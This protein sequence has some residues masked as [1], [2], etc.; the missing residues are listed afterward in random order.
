[1]IILPAIDLH[2]GQCV[3]LVK[4]DYSTAKQVAFDPLE[5]ALQFEKEGASWL[6]MVDLDGAKGG[7][8]P[9]KEIILTI[10]KNSSL[11]VELGGGIRDFKTAVDYLEQGVER[12]ILGSMALENPEIIQQLVARYPDRIAVGIDA[13]DG[14]VKTNGWLKESNQNYLELAKKMESIGV[15]YIIFT[16]ISKD[17]TLKGPNLEQLK[18]IRQAVN[19]HIIASGG[20][21]DI[22]DLK[23]IQQLD[24]Y[25]VICGKSLYVKTLDLKEALMLE[26]ESYVK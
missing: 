11:K 20:I 1:M 7:L 3:R 23:N 24:L 6:H 5:T 19:C 21:R 2:N 14:F 9:N 25:G 15:R 8:Q 17:G 4:G 10:V 13:I 18:Q 12:V 22:N 16:D 26:G